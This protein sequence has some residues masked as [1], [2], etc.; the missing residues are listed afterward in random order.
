MIGIRGKARVLDE[1]GDK[2]LEALAASVTGARRDFLRY[3]AALP[4]FAAQASSR[5]SANWIHDR[6]WHHVR[7]LL[8]DVDDVLLIDLG[9]TR[10][11]VLGGRYRIRMKRHRP[12]AQVATYPTQTAM[13]FMS[14]APQQLVLDGLEQV[15]LIAGYVWFGDSSEI[16]P[17]VLSMRDG[18][19]NV[20]WVHELPETD[21]G[22]SSNVATPLPPRDEH[23]NTQVRLRLERLRSDDPRPQEL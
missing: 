9:V 3:Q 12:P 1:L 17:A 14:Q 2:V 21:L 11:I 20:L 4:D 8:D 15:N 23:A 22:R 5:G 13:D 18:Q 16:G 7:A 10:E 6:L 19:D